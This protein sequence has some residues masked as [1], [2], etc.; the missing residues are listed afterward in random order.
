MAC[1]SSSR[2]GNIRV[3]NHW[4]LKVLGEYEDLSE[5]MKVVINDNKNIMAD[6]KNIIEDNKNLDGELRKIKTQ[7]D[8]IQTEQQKDKGELKVVKAEH[9]KDKDELQVVKTR[10]DQVE[11]ELQELRIIDMEALKPRNRFFAHYIR[12]KQ[13]EAKKALYYTKV[14]R[15]PISLSD[16][17]PVTL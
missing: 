9:H 2:D 14:S 16:A 1:L 15:L 10:L 4:G 17:C 12:D 7:L 6:N 13:P 8:D 11:D 5:Q 3:G